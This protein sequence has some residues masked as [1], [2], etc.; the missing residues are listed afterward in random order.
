MVLYCPYVKGRLEYIC[1]F[2]SDET[3]GFQ[4]TIDTAIQEKKTERKKERKK[5]ERKK[6]AENKVGEIIAIL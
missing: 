6:E 2:L 3:L 1:F 5:R 4:R